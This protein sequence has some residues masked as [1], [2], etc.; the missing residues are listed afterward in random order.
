[1][2]IEMT[3]A[4][5]WAADDMQDIE[6]NYDSLVGNIVTLGGGDA[7]YMVFPKDDGVGK[8]VEI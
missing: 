2:L 1:M 4:D 6:D 8:L 7:S 3:K 5:R